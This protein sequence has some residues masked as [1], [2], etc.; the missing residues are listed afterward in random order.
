MPSSNC[1]EGKLTLTCR[2]PGTGVTG[3]LAPEAGRAEGHGKRG[4]RRSAP[5]RPPSCIGLGLPL[6]D[7]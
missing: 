7:E 4:W 6:R 1:R 2:P 5:T 3:P